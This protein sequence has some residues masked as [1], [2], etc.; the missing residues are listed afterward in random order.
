MKSPHKRTIWLLLALFLIPVLLFGIWFNR[1][2]RQQR[3]DHALIEAIKKNDTQ[4]AIAL[5]DQGADANATDKPYTSVRLGNALAGF[6]NGLRGNRLT[7]ENTVYPSALLVRYDWHQQQ[8]IVARKTENI[9]I[10]QAL[11]DRGANPF[12]FNDSGMTLLH[13]ACQQHHWQTVKLLLHR[14]VPCDL[15]SKFGDPPLMYASDECA[16]LLIEYGADVNTRFQDGT[17]PLMQQNDNPTLQLLLDHHAN[18]NAQDN[19][20]MTPLMHS[21]RNFVPVSHADYVRI[22]LQH[23]AKVSIKDRNGRTASDWVE[24]PMGNPD[25][26]KEVSRLLKEALKKEQAEQHTAGTGSK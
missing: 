21:M 9:E 1:Q 4:T 12:T 20:G 18:I 13:E 22:L 2:V 16:E 3:L 24:D 14:H 8:N 17:T 15:K 10:V 5:L 6:W 7:Q 19:E 25:D 23:R 26:W 11:L